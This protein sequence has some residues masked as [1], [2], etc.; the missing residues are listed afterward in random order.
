M[1]EAQVQFNRDAL[2]VVRDVAREGAVVGSAKSLLIWGLINLGAWVVMGGADP[3]LMAAVAE[4]GLG[5]AVLIYGLLVIA[6]AML[7]VAAVGFAT[8][9]ERTVLGDG[10]MLG[11]V[12][13]WNLG[14]DF[15]ALAILGKYGYELEL[16]PRWMLL[17]VFQL[18]W[19]YRDLMRYKQ[20]SAWPRSELPSDSLR[21]MREA[22]KELHRAPADVAMG[23]V[24]AS[25]TVKGLRSQTVPYSGQL[26]G[27]CAI[28]VSNR[29][30][31]FLCLEKADLAMAVYK[32]KGVTE[33]ATES[34]QAT[35]QWSAVSLLAVKAWCGV[36]VAAEDLDYLRTSGSATKALVEQYLTSP[37]P[38]LREAAEKAH[39]KAKQ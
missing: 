11:I 37:D 35:V 22:I 15:L 18:G 3:E 9:D 33:V 1:A 38:K 29:S 2:P 24:K 4:V 6:V 13:L 30:D 32:P 10:I 25:R 21:E 19:A 23:R 5:M 14:S 8:R 17:G 39:K 28:L 27:D 36:P 12:G 20:I 26:A 7:V 31:D 34:G 16:N